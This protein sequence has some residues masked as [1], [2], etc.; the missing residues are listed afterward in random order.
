MSAIPIVT[1]ISPEEYLRRERSPNS[2]ASTTAVRSSRCLGRV[3][4]HNRIATNLTILSGISSEMDPVRITRATSAS[5]SGAAKATCIP[6]SSYLR[7]RK[8]RGRP[9]RHARQPRVVVIEILSPST[10]SHDRGEKFLDYQAIPSL[11]EYVLMS[12]SPRRFENYRSAGRWLL[13]LPVVVFLAAP[14]GPTIHRLLALGS[15][16]CTSRWRTWPNEAASTS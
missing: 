1:G 14:F 10:E 15:T 13:A 5:A 3:A 7:R 16:T 2:R 4:I 8:V 12:Q 6:I 9:V 11:R